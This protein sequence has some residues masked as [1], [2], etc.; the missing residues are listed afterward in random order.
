MPRLTLVQMKSHIKLYTKSLTDSKLARLPDNL[1]RRFVETIMIARETDED[2]YL[3]SVADMAHLLHLDEDTLKSELS[4]LASGGFVEHREVEPHTARWFVVN[5]QT[6]Q[7]DSLKREEI[8]SKPQIEILKEDF[9]RRRLDEPI[10]AEEEDGDQEEEPH[11][12]EV[13]EI[14]SFWLDLTK[15]YRPNDDGMWASDYI[16]PASDL[17][18]LAGRN[19]DRAKELLRDARALMVKDGFTPYRVAA[20]MPLIH[21]RLERESRQQTEKLE[22]VDGAY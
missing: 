5:F 18:I 14:L 16:T 2:G 20:V 13:E 22:V 15:G 9:P 8:L 3:P 17:R 21:T 7:G 6:Y 12:R 19:V 1:W 10:V 11:I 4:Q